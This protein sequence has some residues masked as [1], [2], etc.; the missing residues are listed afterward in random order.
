MRDEGALC[1][2][3][4]PDHPAAARRHPRGH[5]RR[6]TEAPLP[7]RAADARRL[8]DP[9]LRSEP[10]V[11][12]TGIARGPRRARS[13]SMRDSAARPASPRGWRRGGPFLA[14]G[15]QTGLD[16]QDHIDLVGETTRWLEHTTE[17][18]V[19]PRDD[20]RQP[21]ADGREEIEGTDRMIGHRQDSFP[22]MRERYD[23]SLH[24]RR[25]AVKQV[26]DPG[27][28]VA[29]AIDGRRLAAPDQDQGGPRERE[30]H[31]P[32]QTAAR[33]DVVRGAALCGEAISH[34]PTL[35]PAS[36][37]R[38]HRRIL[39]EVVLRI[40]WTQLRHRDWGT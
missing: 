5:R 20:L 1:R 39:V 2:A 35:T 31:P 22:T 7:L 34:R 36:G 26:L 30:T 3:P 28:H 14:E 11:R 16:G 33:S 12:R 23:A 17:R 24:R 37:S 6:G 29:Q 4:P 25:L 8:G 38:T 15:R 40:S 9:V 19:P 13:R 18:G 32:S 10:R 27:A 21:T